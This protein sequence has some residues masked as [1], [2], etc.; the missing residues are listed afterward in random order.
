[1]YATLK[2]N[3]NNNTVIF[4]NKDKEFSVVLDNKRISD[5]ALEVFKFENKEQLKKFHKE[6]GALLKTL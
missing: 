6:I 4:K 3:E 5:N 2:N 1:M